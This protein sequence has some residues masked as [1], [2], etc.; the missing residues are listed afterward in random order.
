MNA[1]DQKKIHAAAS[2][3]LDWGNALIDLARLEFTLRR[4]KIGTAAIIT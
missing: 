1:G 4:L 2:I 3:L